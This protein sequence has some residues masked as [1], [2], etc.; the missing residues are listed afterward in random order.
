MSEVVV[1]GGESHVQA[2]ANRVIE[3]YVSC[4]RSVIDYTAPVIFNRLPQYL[5]KELVRLEKRPISIITSA[6]CNSAIEV[7][8]TPI[9]EHF[10]VL[11]SRQRRYVLYG[12]QS[13]PRS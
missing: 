4:V 6:K 8:L 9:L 12:N 3:F 2:I 13:K 7:G 10:H 1:K 11:C 5:K